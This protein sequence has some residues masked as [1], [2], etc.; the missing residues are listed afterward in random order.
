M[1]TTISPPRRILLISNFFPPHVKGGAEIACAHLAA[2]LAAQGHAVAV[3]T[4]AP[5]GAGDST[6]DTAQGFRIYRRVI[7]NVYHTHEH[8]RAPGWKKPLWHLLDHRQ[9]NSPGVLREVL[10]DFR[11]DLVNTHAMQGM[12]CNI[13][14]Q[15]GAADLPVVVTL[16]D[17]G[18]VCIRSSMFKNGRTCERLCAPCVVSK[19]IKAAYLRRIRRLSFASPSRALLELLRPHLPAHARHAEYVPNPLMFRPVALHS[20]TTGPV[21][22]LYVGQISEHKGVAFIIEVIE[23]L[24]RPRDF[25]LTL[26]GRGPLLEPLRARFAGRDWVRFEGFVPPEKVA[27]YMA[28]SDAL[29]VPSLWVENAPLVAMEA[30]ALGLP[31]LTSD[32][33]GLP[34]LVRDEET[35]RVLRMGDR[36]QWRSAL[37]AL[38]DDRAQRN[39]W[40]VAAQARRTEFDADVLGR[41]YLALLEKT[42]AAA[43]V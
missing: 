13:W 20:R 38:A 14:E 17:P 23:A 29:L 33:G 24:G 9:P 25:R 37:M 22:L 26:L 4:L 31:M 12:G 32:Q 28:A 18:L 35:G 41:R 34:E 19:R 15:L 42:V 21:E 16:H 40:K 7:A 1:S 5:P 3:F 39:G 6:E 27:D 11:P 2:W 10:A 8:E 43:P 30:I 36:E